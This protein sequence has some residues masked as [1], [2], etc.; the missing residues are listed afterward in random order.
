MSYSIRNK[1]ANKIKNI[2]HFCVISITS[3]NFNA[4]SLFIIIFF[5]IQQRIMK[6]SIKKKK[7]GV[8]AVTNNGLSSLAG[9]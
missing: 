4:F 3:F 1:E 6:Y 7:H 8:I 2:V 5:L 9:F